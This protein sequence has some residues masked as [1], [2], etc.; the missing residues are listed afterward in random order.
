HG[1]VAGQHEVDT[2]VGHQVGLELGDVHVQGEVICIHM[3]VFSA[4]TC[5]LTCINMHCGARCEP[6]SQPPTACLAADK[7]QRGT[8]PRGGR[9][10]YQVASTETRHIEPW[11]QGGSDAPAMVPGLTR[12]PHVP[13]HRVSHSEASA[14]FSDKISVLHRVSHSEA[15]AILSDRVSFSDGVSVPHRVSHSEASAAVPHGRPPHRVSLLPCGD[16]EAN[17]GPP[18]KGAARGTSKGE[19][20]APP[21][22]RVDKRDQE[23]ARLRSLLAAQQ[24]APTASAPAIRECT[25]TALNGSLRAFAQHCDAVVTLT[26]ECLD[27]HRGALRSATHLR[28]TCPFEI[29]CAGATFA[30]WAGLTTHVTECH[31]RHAGDL[32]FVSMPAATCAL[33]ASACLA[34]EA[35]RM[36][37]PV[38]VTNQQFAELLRSRHLGSAISLCAS[39]GAS[40]TQ[41]GLPLLNTVCTLLAPALLANATPKM[42]GNGAFNVITFASFLQALAA[43]LADGRTCP[44]LFLLYANLAMLPLPGTGMAFLEL[45]PTHHH[46]VVW[47]WL[48]GGWVADENGFVERRAPPQ[49]IMIAAVLL[50]RPPV[51]TTPGSNT[52]TCNDAT[53]NDP[54]V[55]GRPAQHVPQ[56][57]LLA[58]G[59]VEANPGPSAGNAPPTPLPPAEP[60]PEPPPPEPPPKPLT[61]NN[62]TARRPPMHETPGS[63]RRLREGQQ[64]E[65][66]RSRHRDGSA[67]PDESAERRR[68][69]E[70]PAHNDPNSLRVLSWNAA[71][72]S[73]DKA[74][75]VFEETMRRPVDVLLLQ[76]LHRAGKDALQVLS[77]AGF[78]GFVHLRTSRT[79]GGVAVFV[80]QTLSVEVIARS[81]PQDGPISTTEWLT[82]RVETATGP[83]YVTSLYCPPQAPD[84]CLAAALIACSATPEGPHQRHI[85]G[86]DFNA[87][88]PQ[89]DA[90]MREKSSRG[91]N[92]SM[93]KAETLTTFSEN[94]DYEICAPPTP[95]RPSA[96]TTTD[97]FLFSAADLTTS[98]NTILTRLSDHAIIA[99]QLGN[100][101][102][103]DEPT[104]AQTRT[105]RRC[106]RIRWADVTE[107]H[108]TLSVASASAFLTSHRK[109]LGVEEHART[110][111]L[112]FKCA[113]GCL[114]LAPLFSSGDA[115][116]SRQPNLPRDPDALWKLVK[117]SD[118][119]PTAPHA[120]TTANDLAD[121]VSRKHADNGSTNLRRLHHPRRKEPPMTIAEIG[122]AVH[123]LRQAGPDGEGLCPRLLKILW[124]R[125][126]KLQTLICRLFACIAKNNRIPAYWRES[127]TIAIPKGTGSGFRPETLTPL[128][129]RIWESVV[130]RRWEGV[131]PPL[132]GQRRIR[133]H[134]DK[135][136]QG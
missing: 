48:D 44:G 108:L 46:C 70:A 58:C 95:T 45:T 114:P 18:K 8:P 106:R 81:A 124:N 86:G 93:G 77:A 23:I 4:L 3:R 21:P 12:V 84:S 119:T 85:I 121:A 80:K 16:I 112:T 127:V 10:S 79:G 134:K 109:P 110:I 128:L 90:V 122:L 63:R 83:L 26:S 130:L 132:S 103:P 96:G 100:T 107:T 32:P 133:K 115:Q 17:P 117:S 126:A 41:P 47:R 102:T 69:R 98:C 65:L 59:D 5:T 29:G 87:R 64:D 111:A 36:G 13:L 118:I 62:N 101:H 56:P 72:L 88:S 52:L 54:V 6:S 25:I 113:Q 42:A 61:S 37:S 78:Q 9:G 68:P 131:L 82:A 51:R 135:E 120:S 125:C 104:R 31:A 97:L 1:R 38:A 57:S 24:P 33:T 74:G 2:G 55:T 67:Q 28:F 105:R 40:A 43:H 89:W 15:R 49:P 73:A 7:G 39:L 71:G 136:A 116:R 92:T 91:N 66:P 27:A 53:F 19:D 11:F 22:R 75:I 35:C 129:C 30:S 14:I 34:A 60:P 94:R 123:S 20:T 99:L 50:A 76:E